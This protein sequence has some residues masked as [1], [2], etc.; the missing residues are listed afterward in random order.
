VTHPLPRLAAPLAAACALALAGC[1]LPQAL[2]DYPSTGT[3]TPPRILSD[4]VTPLDTVV[5]LGPGCAAPPAVTLTASAVY[6][7]T[8]KPFDA[9]WFVD[10]RPDRLLQARDQ[11]RET[12]PVPANGID[13]VRPIT[14]WVFHPYLYDP[15]ADAAA[16]QAFRDGGGIHVVELV[17]SNGFQP[18]P[19]PAARPWRSPDQNFE[20]QVYRWVFRYVP[21]AGCAF[22]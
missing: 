2:P 10:Y 6:D 20:T 9:R 22:P 15:G 5:E 14:P 18:D 13:L 11:S 16:Q 8:T 21:G 4:L 1:P 19:G 17:V 12:I 3:I 7:D